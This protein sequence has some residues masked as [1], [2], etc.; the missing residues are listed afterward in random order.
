MTKIDGLI[1]EKYRI[2]W[3]HNE[4]QLIFTNFSGS[5]ID[6]YLHTD[7]SRFWDF[8]NVGD[9]I[10]KNANTFEINVYRKG[11]FS[12]RFILSYGDCPLKAM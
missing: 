6:L 11:F 10:S 5:E 8:V 4:P 9:S 7:K 1:M 12:K 3:N 2:K